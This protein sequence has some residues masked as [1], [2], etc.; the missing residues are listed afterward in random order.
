ML[1]KTFD[2]YPIEILNQ[3]AKSWQICIK[4]NK[5]SSSHSNCCFGPG[6]FRESGF[7]GLN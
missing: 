1:V 5:T 4:T 6:F 3:N 7:D 2:A